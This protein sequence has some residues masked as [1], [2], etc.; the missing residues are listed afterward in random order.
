MQLAVLNQFDELLYTFN[1]S[2]GRS[3]LFLA[4]TRLNRLLHYI[5]SYK[6]LIVW[7]GSV[8]AMTGPGRV[9]GFGIIVRL[10][11]LR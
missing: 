9:W 8:C 7:N 4:C 1:F 11:T 6:T 3:L 5:P 10:L 2:T